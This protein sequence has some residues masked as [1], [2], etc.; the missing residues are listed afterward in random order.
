MGE[1]GVFL[2]PRRRGTCPKDG[3]QRSREAR[4]EEKDGF[5]KALF[6]PLRCASGTSQL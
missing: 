2:S 1:W 4:D 6:E 5:L 3:T